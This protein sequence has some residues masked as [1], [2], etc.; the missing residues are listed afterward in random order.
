M[1][2]LN[3]AQKVI[4]SGVMG[5]F[6]LLLVYFT[7]VSLAQSFSHAVTQFLSLSYL[8]V[9]L[10]IGFAAQVSLFSYSRLFIKAIHQG[11]T[12]VGASGG[13]S[14]VSIIACCAHH[15]TDFAPFIGFTAAAVF[16]T[17]YQTFFIVVGLFSNVIGITVMLAIMQKH[18]LY[19]AGGTFRGLM[20]LDLS[21]IR[22]SVIVVSLVAIFVFGL[23]ATTNG[24]SAIFSAVP[25]SNTT[26]TMYSKGVARSLMSLPTKY[27]DSNGLSIQVTPSPLSTGSNV[28]FDI[29]MDTHAGDLSF[30]LTKV[31]YLTAGNGTRYNPIAWS[32]SPPGGH[33]REGILTFPPLS[34]TPSSLTLYLINVYGTDRTFEWILTS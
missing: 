18:H 2:K 13:V 12:S 15:L 19:L 3:N 31:T 8:L 27:S 9:P 16:L 26:N 33:H 5:S 20:K 6:G 24:G 1:Q 29:K 21:K 11:S 14:T 28:S 4:I 23:I 17:A 22:N 30:D 25:A 34:G 10:V 7:I 32:G